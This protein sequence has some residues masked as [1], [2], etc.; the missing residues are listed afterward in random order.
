MRFAGGCRA[1]EIRRSR[2]FG[3][4][5]PAEGFSETGVSGAADREALGIGHGG[6]GAQIG[7]Q[8]SDMRS[9][10][11]LG[12]EVRVPVSGSCRHQNQQKIADTG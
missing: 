11:G 6:A 2:N 3:N 1:S 8:A 12:A 7:I 5:G 10:Y 9:S 4:S